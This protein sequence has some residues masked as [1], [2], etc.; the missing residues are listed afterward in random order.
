MK[1]NNILIVLLALAVFAGCS[2]S[3]LERP[4]KDALV[5]ANFYKTN[6]QVLAGTAGLY[7]AV[8]KDYIDQAN[9]KLGD[10]RGGTTFRAWGDRD[11][12]LFNTSEV[13]ADNAA[14]YRAFFVI[15]G[16]ANLAI[17]NISTYAG[18]GVTEEVKNHAIA[19]ARF[20]RATAYTHLVSNYGD[21]PIIENN[22]DHLTNPYL[23]KNTYQSVWEFIT[24]DYEFAAENLMDEA[25]APGRITK[26]SAKGMLARTYLTRAGVESTGGVRNKEFLNKARD[27]ADD[28]IKNSGKSLLT[29]YKDLFLYSP[30]YKYDNNPESLF[31][32]Q[33]VFTP[34]YQYANTMVSQITYSNAI[35]ANGDGWGGDISATWWMLSLYDGL[36]LDNGATPGRT[37]DQR[38]KATYMLPGFVYEEI[39]E[40]ATVDGE[41]IERDLTFPDP[42]AAADNS[43]ASIK[44]YV[45]GGSKD[46]GGEADRQRYPNNT[47]MLRLAEMYLIYA[48]AVLGDNASTSDETALKYFNKVYQRAYKDPANPDPTAEYPPF[49]GELDWRTIFEERTKEF[50]MESMLWY[51]LVRLHYYNPNAAYAIIAEQDRGLFVVHPNQFPNPTRW[52]FAKTSWFADRSAVA[53]EGN[54]LLPLPASEVSQAPSLAEEAVPYVFGD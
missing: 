14:A 53:N 11:H 8:W 26:W 50:A 12:V 25:I 47:Y 1:K 28:V 40:K 29:Y 42:G 36:I 52:T 38:L 9:F 3:F 5:D 7:N 16:Q 35:A 32:L 2:D 46:T 20:M 15:V 6:E 49:T 27:Y 44:K 13:S 18:A 48:E 4:P 24:R 34:V 45:V 10:F 21:V 17:Q 33:W 39:T 22:L 37:E 23:V 30:G 31:E 51:D 54:F 43:Y 41:Q 19:E